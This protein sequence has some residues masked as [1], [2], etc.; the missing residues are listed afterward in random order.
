WASQFANRT[1][2]EGLAGS[3]EESTERFG[4]SDVL[5]G[6]WL[7]PVSVA[8]LLVVLGGLVAF[9]KPSAEWSDGPRKL[10]AKGVMGFAHFVAHLACGAAVGL[11][12]IEFA[13]LFDGAMFTTALLIALAVV[14]GLA[15]AL[16]MG[17][18]L[19]VCCAWLRAHGN[20]AF[21]SMGLTRYKNFLRLHIDRDGVLRIYPIGLDRASS[22]WRLDPENQDNEASWLAPDG[23][24]LR[25]RLIESPI[26]IDP[27]VAPHSTVIG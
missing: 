14:G 3:L 18:Y 19:A 9:A 27:K 8:L 24:E 10:V 20:E 1:L 11:L 17:I 13:S 6:L 25:P 5:L 21:S 7:N 15:G 22:K 16:V 12:V 4:W 2:N 26:V 23:T